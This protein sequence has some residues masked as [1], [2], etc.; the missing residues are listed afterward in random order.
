MSYNTDKL[1]Y[2]DLKTL[3]A[4]LKQVKIMII[5]DDKD[6]CELLSKSLQKKGAQTYCQFDSLS[7]T[8][9]AND[10]DPNV[11]LLDVMLPDKSGI[12]LLSD[13]RRTKQ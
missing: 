12:E 11:V 6:F 5:D 8:K 13:I 2:K 7:L 9:N 4:S 3:E 1:R 10:F